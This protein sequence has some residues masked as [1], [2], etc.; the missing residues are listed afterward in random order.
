MEMNPHTSSKTITHFVPSDARTARA[1][2]KGVTL[3]GI[4]LLRNTN[5]QT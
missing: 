2:F 5:K 4:D 1:R 3:P